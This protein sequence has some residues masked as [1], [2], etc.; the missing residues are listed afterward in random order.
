MK[1]NQRVEIM[2]KSK[3]GETMTYTVTINSSG[4]ATIPKA[5]R[6]FLGVVPGKNPLTFDIIKNKVIVGKGK[7]H[8]E[9]FDESIQKIRNR[10][11]EAERK[12]PKTK[13]LHEKY[14]SMTFNE[15][16]DAYDATEEG[17]KEFEEKYGIRL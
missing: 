13:E 14:N 6:E 15:V 8:E 3:N 2:N 11:E 10:I 9:I 16:R 4:Q 17:K 5:V 12:D 1:N 7:S